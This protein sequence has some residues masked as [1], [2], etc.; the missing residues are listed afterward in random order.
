WQIEEGEKELSRLREELQQRSGRLQK[1]EAQLAE[2]QQLLEQLQDKD[3]R[4]QNLQAGIEELQNQLFQ[5]EE[6]IER[7]R[8]EQQRWLQTRGD[9][10]KQHYAY[11]DEVTELRLQL[12]QRDEEIEKLK[13]DL[14]DFQETVSAMSQGTRHYRRCKPSETDIILRRTEREFYPQE[15]KSF[16][17][18]ILHRAI[19]Q[20]HEKSRV[21]HILEDLLQYND[22]QEGNRHRQDIM[23]SIDDLFLDYRKWS[24]SHE[25][26]LQRLGFEITSEDNHVKIR[27]HRDPR[28]QIILS[29]TPSD[30]RAGREII[31]EI[32]KKIFGL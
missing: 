12:Q 17:L 24:D 19:D 2:Q 28:Y 29:R 26:K 13:A 31:Q 7:L 9:S 18:E 22:A 21:R 32:R 27:F 11:T 16:I 4:V 23:G 5:R 25:R 14:E 6:E 8:A 1:L 10:A 20:V 3:R 30:W 15:A